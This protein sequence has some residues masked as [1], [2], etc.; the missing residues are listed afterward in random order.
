M[1]GER[2]GWTATTMSLNAPLFNKAAAGR[3]DPLLIT[4]AAKEM[5]GKLSFGQARL[6]PHKQLDIVGY[7][8][9]ANIYDCAVI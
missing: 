7:C 6:A 3:I 2:I 8:H 4:L 5:L 9:S 1:I